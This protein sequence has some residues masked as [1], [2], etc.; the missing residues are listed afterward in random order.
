VKNAPTL[1]RIEYLLYSAVKRML[2]A[3][4]H[5]S[6]Q[7]FGRALGSFGYLVLARQRK[8]ADANL[9]LTLPHLTAPERSRVVRACFRHFGSAFCEAASAERFT[10]DDIRQLFDIEGAEHL[11]R[12]QAEGRGLLATC[13]H[14]GAWQLAPYALGLLLGKLSVVVRPPDN[15]HISA[16]M[17]RVR[18]RCGVTVINRAG[19]SHQLYRFVKRGGALGMVVDQRVHKGTGIIVPF[20]DHP[21]R[22]SSIPAFIATKT[23]APMLPMV[24]TPQADGRYRLVISAPLPVT[25]E[26]P[27]AVAA[28]TTLMLGKIAEDIRNKPEL[29]LWMHRRWEL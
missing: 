19:S 28:L 18:Q 7:R 10:S 14:Y 2:L 22:S 15:P 25:G 1:H 29:W 21:A 6:A 26:G 4:S 27:E 20:L 13:G 16:D 11:Q 12:A 24:C 23:G 9:R 8:L 17:T 3:R 5:A